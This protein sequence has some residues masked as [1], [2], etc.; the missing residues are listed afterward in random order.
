MNNLWI[1]YIST[2][3]FICDMNNYPLVSNVLK[4]VSLGKPIAIYNINQGGLIIIIGR[5]LWMKM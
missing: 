3:S 1:L 5:C 4:N 2:E